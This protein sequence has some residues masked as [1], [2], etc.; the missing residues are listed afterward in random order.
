[1]GAGT[2]P[3]FSFGDFSTHI[4]NN[5]A[6]PGEG[7]MRA[8]VHAINS[9][10]GTGRNPP[11]LP[12]AVVQPSPAPVLLEGYKRAMAALWRGSPSIELFFCEP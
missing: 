5:P 2:Y 3:S 6:N 9:E 8:A 11:G 7:T 10:I 12:I 1:M 4:R